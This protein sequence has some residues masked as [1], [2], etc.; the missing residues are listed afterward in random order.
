MVNYLLVVLKHYGEYSVTTGYQCVTKHASEDTVLTD[1][2]VGKVDI[3]RTPETHIESVK[4]L[5]PSTGH[6]RIY[7][8]C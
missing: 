3:R 5:I 7:F 2:T 1:V 8:T 6:L 4:G